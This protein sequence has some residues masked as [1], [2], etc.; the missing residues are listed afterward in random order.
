MEICYVET[1]YR[2]EQV[3]EQFEVAVVV[4]DLVELGRIGELAL[5]L[6]HDPAEFGHAVDQQ[7][8]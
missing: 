1:V 7:P 3:Q 2:P 8:L 5:V 6:G 4:V